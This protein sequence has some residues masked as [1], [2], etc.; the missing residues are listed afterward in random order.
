MKTLMQNPNWPAIKAELEKDIQEA[1]DRHD[2]EEWIRAVRRLMVYSDEPP[3]RIEI[4]QSMCDVLAKQSQENWESAF[5]PA[6][7]VIRRIP[8]VVK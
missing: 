5:D 3:E 7:V 4:T 8:V 6:Q 1:E 2:V